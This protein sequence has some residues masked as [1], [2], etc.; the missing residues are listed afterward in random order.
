MSLSLALGILVSDLRGY[1]FLT[2]AHA[3]E[4]PCGETPTTVDTLSLDNVLAPDGVA[5]HN[6]Y[7]NGQLIESGVI[8]N[9]VRFVDGS[10]VNADGVVVGNEGPADADGV[11]VGNEAPCFNGVV[12]GN[13][14]PDDPGDGDGA[15]GPDGVVVGNEANV[16]GYIVNASGRANGGA[17]TGD[18]I[19]IT[20][21]V[22][23][24]QN[25]L[26]SGS[27]IDGGIINITGTITGV[28]ITPAN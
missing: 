18:N 15:S 27:T 20:N 6:I 11:V 3:Q 23:T 24:G 10:V 19:N 5:V 14:R 7:V 12:V 9:S 13:E 8:A 16:S 22:I 21:G 26:L 28:N 1:K 2:S 4:S 25:L 17:L